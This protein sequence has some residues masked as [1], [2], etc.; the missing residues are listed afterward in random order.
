VFAEYIQGV[1]R[2]P[3]LQQ[4]LLAIPIY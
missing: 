1:S 4:K 3:S 2:N